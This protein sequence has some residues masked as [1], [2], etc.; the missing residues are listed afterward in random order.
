MEKKAYITPMMNIHG[1][2][3]ETEILLASKGPMAPQREYT[4]L[5]AGGIRMG[6]QTALSK[7][8]GG[9]IIDDD[10]YDDDDFDF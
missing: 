5:N 8:F 4:K 3:I 6:T 9:P 1:L 2:K 7:G 10:D